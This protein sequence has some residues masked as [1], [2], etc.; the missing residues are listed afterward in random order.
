MAGRFSKNDREWG[1]GLRG[2]QARGVCM[3][4]G[5]ALHLIINEH[6]VAVTTSPFSFST[7]HATVSF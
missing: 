1:E 5:F 2:R 3:R 4:M 6:E 7:T